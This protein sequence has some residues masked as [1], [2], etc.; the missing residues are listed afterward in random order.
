MWSL[1]N[2]SGCVKNHRAMGKYIKSREPEAVI[3]YENSHLEFKAVPIGENYSDISD[4]E[5]R[6]YS[7]LEYTE[8]Y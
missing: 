4:V 2:E 5:S 6:M 1:G 7:S 8:E 3:H